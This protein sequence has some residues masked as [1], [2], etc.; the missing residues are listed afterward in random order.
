MVFVVNSIGTERALTVTN[1]C[2]HAHDPVSNLGL[3]GGMRGDCCTVIVVL[4]VV[5]PVIDI[6]VHALHGWDCYIELNC[7]HSIVD[8]EVHVSRRGRA[9]FFPGGLTFMLS[10]RRGP[11]QALRAEVHIK[12]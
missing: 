10:P 3:P 4:I 5:P 12:R 8:V 9:S 2:R 1:Y 7:W 11:Y 6:K